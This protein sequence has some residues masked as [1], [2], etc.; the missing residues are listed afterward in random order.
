MSK[1]ID[2]PGAVSIEDGATGPMPLPFVH[3]IR[4]RW[5]DCDPAAIAYTPNIP[6]WALEAIEAWWEHHAGIDWY[7]I[8]IDRD[9]GTPFVHMSLDFRA[10]VT[11]RHM[12]ECEVVLKRL[13]SR[14]VTHR[15]CG[16]QNGVLCFEGEFVAVFVHSKA[17]VPR[18]PPA[19]ILAAIQS[20]VSEAD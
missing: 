1:P 9:L 11:P 10:P 17:M 12:L 5:G 14:A 8:N 16:R 20:V 15:V 3:P 19:D 18:T 7:H 6:A 4:V 13:G 2:K